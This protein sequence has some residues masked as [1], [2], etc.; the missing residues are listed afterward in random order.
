MCILKRSAA[1]VAVL[2]A[3]TL[4][5]AASPVL[6]AQGVATRNAQPVKEG[7]RSDRPFDARFVDVAAEAGLDVKMVV[8][9]EVRKKYIIEANGTG[10]AFFDY[11]NDGLIDLYLVNGSTLDPPKAD[12]QPISRLY[13]NQ[14]KGR[15]E[16][17]TAA[18]GT[19]RAGW[20]GG[21]CVADYDNDGDLDMYVGYWGVN[22]LYR[23][24]G[25]GVF[26]DVAASTGAAGPAREWTSGCTFVD[27]DRDGRLDLLVTRY[28]EFDLKTAPPPGKASNCEWKGMS[29]FCGP[30]GLP[31]GGATL[32]HANQDGTF[33]DVSAAV[34]VSD[35]GEYYAFTAIAADLDQN[36]W[37]DLYVACDSTPNVFFINEEG[38]LIDFAA[39]TGLA[40]NEHGFEQ[41]GMGVGVGDFNNDGLLDL[42]KT[43]FAGDYPNLYRNEGDGVFEDV[44]VRAGLA[45]NPQLVGWG[46]GM[47]DLDNDGLQDVM[48]VSG[49]VYPELEREGGGKERY[50]QPTVIYR[51]LGDEK[52]DDVSALAG[53]ALAVRRSSRGAAFGD[54]DNDGDV[55]AIVMNMGAAPTLL[56]NDLKNENHWIQVR[57][58]GVKSNR[59]AIGATVRV[60][61]GGAVQARAVLSQDSFLSHSDL[62]QHFGFGSAGRV[63]KIEVVWPSGETEAFPATAADRRVLLLEGSG[64]IRIEE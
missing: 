13:R 15:F 35:V 25:G 60:H 29:V 40:F 55:D 31:Y 39:E 9:S 36:G 38:T 10:V 14:G 32:Y 64:E 17:V 54:Y 11:D 21:V 23:N 26:K 50:L 8:G 43:N 51:N 49:H 62:R 59:S 63:D 46:V 57:L 30:R 19:G 47:I 12:E 37:T 44:V 58:Q 33:E 61:A 41:G 34:G 53:E 45:R 16:D 20:G 52:F 27:Y 4:A 56:R 28:Q 48:Q 42:V 18:S 22:S 5:L 2:A 1:A 24:E 3:L 7:P 6:L